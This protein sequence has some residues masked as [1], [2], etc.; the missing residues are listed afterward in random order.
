MRQRI[1]TAIALSSSPEILICDEPTTAVDV[2]TQS[3]ILELIGSMKAKYGLSVLFITHN[4]GV[5]AGIADKVA[6]MYAGK[7]VEYG[8]AEEIFT[9]PAHPYTWALLASTPDPETAETLEAI[10]GAPPNM[11][12]PPEGA[13][14]AERKKYAVEIDFIREPPEFKISDT[15]WA[16]TWLLHPKARRWSA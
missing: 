8:L 7:I 11:I 1:V 12:A 3:Q 5:V 13:A 9:S 4:L 16:A 15:H 6:V 10:P 2:T 14:F